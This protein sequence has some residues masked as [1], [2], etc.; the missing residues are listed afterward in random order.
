MRIKEKLIKA[1]K[2]IGAAA[3]FAVAIPFVSANASAD[4]VGAFEVTGEQ[5]IPI[6]PMKT[7]F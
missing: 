5:R 4:T 1:L 7:A 2:F 3:A 6:I